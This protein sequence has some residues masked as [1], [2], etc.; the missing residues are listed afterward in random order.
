MTK[1]RFGFISYIDL[2]DLIV[3]GLTFYFSTLLAAKLFVSPAPKLLLSL[4]MLVLAWIINFG[5]KRKLM[6][7]P[8]I[9]EHFINWWFSGVDSFDPDVDEKAVPLLITQEMQAGHAVT[10]AA[11]QVKTRPTRTRR[12]RV[13]KTAKDAN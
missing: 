5:I 3:L 9:F 10:Q 8:G 7:Y 11:T 1:G 2:S 13:P 6:P 4:V 12:P